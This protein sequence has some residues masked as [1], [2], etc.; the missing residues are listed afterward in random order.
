MM[1][2]LKVLLPANRVAV[3]VAVLTG[4][5]AAAPAVASAFYG[6]PQVS[7]AVVAVAGLATAALSILKFLDGSQKWD[8]LSRSPVPFDP[9]EYDNEDEDLGVDSAPEVNNSTQ[10]NNFGGG[11]DEV[12]R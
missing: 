12:P 10:V 6:V 7:E 3:I 11:A 1:E 2:R 5:V 4:I 8:E 9:F